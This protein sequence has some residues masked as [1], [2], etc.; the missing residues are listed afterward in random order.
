[1]IHQSKPTEISDFKNVPAEFQVKMEFL[2]QYLASQKGGNLIKIGVPIWYGF[3]I[4]PTD[5]TLSGSCLNW[6]DH[7]T[8]DRMIA[9]LQAVRKLSVEDIE[10]HNWVCETLAYE[11]MIDDMM[12][13]PP[14]KKPSPAAPIPGFVYLINDGH[15]Y[16]KIGRTRS[17][18]SRIQGA[19]FGPSCSIVLVFS[20]DDH[21][22]KERELHSQYADKRIKGE[23]FQLSE[24][25]I[26]HIRTTYRNCIVK[27]G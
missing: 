3:T 1:M 2:K 8:L 25:D 15:G 6:P 21:I 7:A 17:W 18:K 12:N 16:I 13:Q 4:S 26:Q 27:E 14:K 9:Y 5:I 23:W 11:P 19:Q 24:I 20:C 22:E 10:L